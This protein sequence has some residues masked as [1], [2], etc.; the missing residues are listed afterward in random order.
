LAL[1]LPISA[2]SL[3][4]E[5]CLQSLRAID[6]H[7]TIN[8]IGRPLIE[9]ALV[10][11]ALVIGTGFFGVLTARVVAVLVVVCLNGLILSRRLGFYKGVAPIYEIKKLAS[12]SSSLFLDAVL[13][14]VLASIDILI[15]G[16][17]HDSS[18]VGIYKAVVLVATPV[19]MPL[20]AFRIVIA[21]MVANCHG[22]Q[23]YAGLA[24]IFKLGARW[25][26]TLSFP[27]FF[28]VLLAQKPV[29]AIFGPE[30]AIGAT[31][32]IVLCVGRLFDTAVGSVGVV[33]RM[34]GYSRVVLVDSLLLM[35]LSLI[36]NFVLVP[37]YGIL[38]A[39]LAGSAC[40]VLVNGLKL[41]QVYRFLHIHPYSLDL[42]KPLL[43]GVVSF[44][45]VLLASIWL[46]DG[47]FEIFVL[48]CVM[49][50]LYLVLLYG[51]GLAHEDR[52]VLRA[53]YLRARKMM[54]FAAD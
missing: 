40:V 8:Q 9:L 15:L 45:V 34:T 29:L 43:A 54:P 13:L 24:A 33:L 32:L 50:L 26:F 14:L 42:L 28:S 19:V 53:V 48:L 4:L 35:A 41:I 44:A 46:G 5:S 31:S 10:G 3:V 2:V 52:A 51:L 11:I 39:A 7:A 47:L 23:D 30:F 18:L 27:I 22:R 25:T 37:R 6:W 1:S 38:G 20:L 21:P 16:Y 36:L 49:W 17:F 12:F